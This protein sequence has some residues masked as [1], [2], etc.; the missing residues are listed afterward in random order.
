[1][2]RQRWSQRE[3]NVMVTEIGKLGWC[4]RAADS[5]A[6]FMRQPL[7]TGTGITDLIRGLGARLPLS[8]AAV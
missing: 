1:M 2:E 5:L 6:G 3:K 4:P 8:K 7:G